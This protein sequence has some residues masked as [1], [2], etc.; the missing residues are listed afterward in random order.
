MSVFSKIQP[1]DKFIATFI[2]KG[3][4]LYL[5]WFLLYDNWLLKD[6]LVDHFLIEHLVYM[7]DFILSLFGYETFKYAD[8]IGIDGT[9][10]VLIGTPC[11]GLTVFAVFI[12]F[13]LLF[14]GKIKHKLIFIPIGLIIIHVLNILRLVG[15]AIIVLH[16]PDSLEFNHKYTFTILI[17]STVFLLWMLWI[18]KYATTK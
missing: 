16:S 18:K 11:N 15:L 8:A 17:Y 9:H 2:L 4:V 12:G 10:G 14:P 6:G 7:T 13:I 1:Q 5:I 3:I